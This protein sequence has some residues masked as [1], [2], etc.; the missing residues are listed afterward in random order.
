MAYQVALLNFEG[1]LDLLLQLVERA[2][3]SAAELSMA[4]LT[5][6]YLEY[7]QSLTTL[8]AAET[9]RFAELAARLL[10]IKSLSLFPNTDNITE[11]EE[12]MSLQEQLEA[13]GTYQ[14][15][16]AALAKLFGGSRHSWSR[17]RRTQPGESATP[18]NLTVEALRRAFAATL[19]AVPARLPATSP[20]EVSL[21]EMSQRLTTACNR[22]SA[23]DL[24]DFFSK[25]ASRQEIVVA[26]LAALDLWRRGRIILTQPGQFSI[27]QITHVHAST[28]PSA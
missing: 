28:Y 17:S 10:Y 9:S 4:D 5:E 24:Q 23:L 12:I 21:A 1:P 2:R 13:Y 11:N 3:L 7:I 26:F 18:P 14:E 15:S 8:D 16:A 25:L 27:I 20:Q 22:R 19:K 6:Q